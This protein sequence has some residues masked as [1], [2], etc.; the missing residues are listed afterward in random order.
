MPTLGKRKRVTTATRRRRY[1]RRG[2][3]TNSRI[4]RVARQVVLKHAETKRHAI[5]SGPLGLESVILPDN[6]SRWV[7]SNVMDLSQGLSDDTMIGTQIYARGLAMKLQFT[8]TGNF[9]PYFKFFVVEANAA[10]LGGT[11]SIFEGALGNGMLD[12]IK[13][14]YKILK[15]IVVNPILRGG[16][17]GNHATPPIFRK[18]WIPLNKRYDYRT[19]NVTNGIHKNVAV[20]CI[21]YH[22]GN[23][24]NLDVGTVSAHSTLYYKDF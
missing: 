18:I 22:D 21:A 8:Y 6:I 5:A 15:S 7:F 9:A 12:N 23:P 11:N 16:V 4:A 2:P 20:V 13:K 1:V 10:L 14:Q 17:G 24:L 3:T 19:D